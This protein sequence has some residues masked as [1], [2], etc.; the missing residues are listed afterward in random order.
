M[1]K[2]FIIKGNGP[3]LITGPH[4]VKTVRA[5]KLHDK[6]E[7]INKIINKIYN[8]L[9]PNLCTIM[10]WNNKFIKKYNLYPSDPN[11]V[12]NIKKSIWFKKLKKFKIKKP[13]FYLHLDFHGMKNSTTKNHIEVG[14]KAIHLHRPGF[15]SH[16]KP[17]IKKELNELDTLVGFHSHLQG[18]GLDKYT[19]SNQGVL[20][21]FFSLQMELSKCIRKKILNDGSFY[22]KFINS[23][24]II[25]KFW[26][27]EMKKSKHRNKTIK[28]R[29]KN[30][31]NKT[32]K[33]YKK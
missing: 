8:T 2:L 27:K 5:N 33:K 7:Y 16:M 17:I 14:M 28:K 23:I 30:I 13:F 9:G 10:L 31:K 11:F 26:K 18:Y 6:E 25:Y 20:L 19:V 24:K 29:G 22:N 4:S 3:I 15:S 32:R 1:D 12:K 21:G